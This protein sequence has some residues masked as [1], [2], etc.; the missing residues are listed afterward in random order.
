LSGVVLLQDC[1]QEFGAELVNF[2]LAG[3]FFVPRNGPGVKIML[4]GVVGVMRLVVAATSQWRSL[5]RIF[6][7]GTGWRARTIANLLAVM[8]CQF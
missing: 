4:Y 6:W 1:G 2:R 3:F 8:V 5:P 7:L